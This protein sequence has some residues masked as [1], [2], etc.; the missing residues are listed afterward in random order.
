MV[1]ANFDNLVVHLQIY[2][3]YDVTKVILEIC[4]SLHL[5]SI[6]ICWCHNTI[7]LHMCQT[8]KLSHINTIIH[9]HFH[10]SFTYFKSDNYFMDPPTILT[11][12]HSPL[13]CLSY[14]LLLLAFPSELS[15]STSINVDIML[16]L[17]LRTLAGN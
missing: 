17:S 7:H 1:I 15:S 9:L 16:L 13:P 3:I 8:I 14:P 12:A 5:N 11:S 6:V 2:I 4:I 10:L